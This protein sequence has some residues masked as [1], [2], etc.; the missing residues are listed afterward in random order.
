MALV[1]QKCVSCSKPVQEAAVELQWEKLKETDHLENLRTNEW[2]TLKE[3]LKK[4][5]G[6]V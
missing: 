2:S 5:D 4:W 3:I 6:R 1:N